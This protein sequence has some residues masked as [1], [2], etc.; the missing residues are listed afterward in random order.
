MGEDHF[1]DLQFLV[2]LLVMTGQNG[3]QD[4]FKAVL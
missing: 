3:Q 4:E 2:F 1:N